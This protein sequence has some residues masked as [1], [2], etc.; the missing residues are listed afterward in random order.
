MAEVAEAAPGKVD[1]EALRRQLRLRRFI[2]AEAAA[3]RDRNATQGGAS[4]RG[5]VR[6]PN[7]R[8]DNRNELGALRRELKQRRERGAKVTDAEYTPSK[9][10]RGIA[11]GFG[12]GLYLACLTLGL[13]WIA[14]Y[15]YLVIN[16]TTGS[17]Q[18]LT[19]AGFAVII[20]PALLLSGIGRDLRYLLSGK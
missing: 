17:S 12:Q 8:P 7:A 2:A 6:A 15:S 3:A 19:P 10:A 11:Y 14:G 13:T 4:L 1:L 16:S 9:S 18:L 5:A 20:V